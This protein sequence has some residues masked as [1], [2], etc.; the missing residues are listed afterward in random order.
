MRDKPSVQNL[1]LTAR[2][3]L[4]E[5]LLPDLPWEKRYT[6]LMVASAMAVAARE[7]DAGEVPEMAEQEA[8]EAIYRS[9]EPLEELNR[10]FATDLR[11]GHFDDA[12]KAVL[13][14]LRR[15]VIARLKEC[16]P[17]YLEGER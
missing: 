8:L 13:D 1:L 3:A 16:N 7:A 17:R 15:S 4:L 6:A 2:K 11:H 9:G 10:R 12:P 5:D 14:I